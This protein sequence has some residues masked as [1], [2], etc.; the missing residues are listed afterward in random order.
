MSKSIPEIQIPESKEK[1]MGQIN[2]LEMM[3]KEDT[4]DHDRHIHETALNDLQKALKQS[5][6]SESLENYKQLGFDGEKLNEI[7]V[8]LENGIDLLPYA[9]KGF[10]A[11]QLHEIHLGQKQG[12]NTEAYAKKEFN[13]LQ[14]GIIRIGLEHRVDV[15]VYAKPE[16]DGHQM[17]EIRIGLIKG[18]DVNCYANPNFSWQ[19]MF[20]I[21][22]GLEKGID[23]SIFA[24]E[25]FD[26]S[27]MELLNLMLSR[28]MD[29]SKYA[30]PEVPAEEMA[31]EYFKDIG[32]SISDNEN[33]L[34]SFDFY[35]HYNKTK[36]EKIDI[37]NDHQ[38]D[39][40]DWEHES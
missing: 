19:Q 8:G 14:M 6:I 38:T 27:Q 24:K 36:G 33:P 3:V 29:V 39:A 12:V 15:S 30:M 17:D 13:S 4:N 5:Q 11:S 20:I 35:D 31:R 22:N 28:N 32:I 1:I 18:L 26:Q 37:E 9:I 25:E 34:E 7:K 16:Y 21:Q 10:D 2:A 40:C 23:V